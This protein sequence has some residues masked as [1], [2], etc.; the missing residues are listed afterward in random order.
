MANTSVC[1]DTSEAIEL[2]EP[3]GLYLKPV[4]KLNICAQL[5]QLKTPGKT[6]S[7]WEVMEKVKHMIRPEVF[8]SVKV[9]KSTMEFIRLEGEIENKSKLALLMMKLDSKTIKLSGF[10]ESLKIR[11]AEAKVPFPVR[12]DW[13][14]Y[15]RDAKNM[16]ELKPG[17]RPDTVHLKDLPTRWF[18]KRSSKEKSKEEKLK[19]S[20]EILR[21]VFETF[22][23]VRAVDIPLLDPYRKEIM[24][25]LAKPG[26]IQTFTYGQDLTFEAFVQ[27]K[28]Y[29]SFV[30]AMDALRGMKLLFKEDEN[31]A[32]TANIKVDFDKTK[33]L[34]D[35]MIRK[36]R[37]EREKLEALE[38]RLK[39]ARRKEREEKRRLKHLERKQKEEEERMQL[40]IA[41]EERRLLIAQRKL[42]SLRLLSELFERV[43]EQRR[44]LEEERQKAEAKIQKKLQ[45]RRQEVELREKILKNKKEQIQ[46]DK[47]R[48]ELRQKLSGTR[49]LKSAVIMKQRLASIIHGQDKLSPPKESK[50]PSALERVLQ[51][52]NLRAWGAP[53]DVEPA[54]AKRKPPIVKRTRKKLLIIKR[55]DDKP[56]DNDGDSSDSADSTV[57]IIPPPK[58]SF[59][60]P[61][62][63]AAMRPFMGPPPGFPMPP[64]WVFPPPGIMPPPWVGPPP[65]PGYPVPP[66]PPWDFQP[67]GPGSHRG[68][69]RGNFHVFKQPY[70][71]K[72]NYQQRGSVSHK[73]AQ[74]LSTKK[75]T[76]GRFMYPL[77]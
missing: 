69:G 70:L 49:R 45:M 1:N 35:K 39:E 73:M 67:R 31:K 11:V 12:H 14:S 7:N 65:P 46:Q 74:K 61:D 77:T 68:R 32:L 17:E 75:D 56:K 37:M 22:G 16:N 38:R 4:A 5:P 18:A 28:E 40:K 53:D 41:L 34:S 8:L 25:T 44:R 76:E 3:Q 54:S 71:K 63:P 57:T 29:I 13:D 48:E 66:R 59:A 42:E 51:R 9:V 27:F 10:S 52:N 72:Y 64:P 58:S 6:I 55:V 43:K 50:P 15:F 26:T 19:P 2:Y 30:K 20:E 62:D 24:G 36:R 23:D 21:K 47:Q 60:P 33:H